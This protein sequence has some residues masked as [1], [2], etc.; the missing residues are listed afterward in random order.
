MLLLVQAGAG[1]LGVMTLPLLVPILGPRVLFAALI[2]FSALTLL[3]IQFLPDYP[4]QADAPR[5]GDVRRRCAKDQDAAA[6]AAVGIPVPGGKHGPLRVHHRPGPRSRPRDVVHQPDARYLQLVRHAGRIAG[7][8]AVDALWHPD[9]DRC[10]HGADDRR[11]SRPRLGPDRMGLGRV[12]RGR[13]DHLEFRDRLP[14]RH[15]RPVRPDW[16][17]GGLGRIRVEDGARVRPPGRLAHP[18]RGPLPGVDRD[19]S[20]DPRARDAG[21][22]DPGIAPGPGQPGLATGPQRLPAARGFDASRLPIPMHVTRHGA[23]CEPPW[24]DLRRPLHPITPTPHTRLRL[25]RA[26]APGARI[27]PPSARAR[28]PGCASRR[29]RY[30]SRARRRPRA[31]ARP[32]GAYG[33][34]SSC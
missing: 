34:G 19:R 28:C 1:G 33:H 22:R 24:T 9:A 2:G 15:V 7:R 30:V 20:R 18:R 6:R 13:G 26:A 4:M 16:P 23:A 31:S 25:K 3:M 5:P 32:A 11:D 29:A 27:R 17:G 21:V 12:K 10:R 14:A 8:R